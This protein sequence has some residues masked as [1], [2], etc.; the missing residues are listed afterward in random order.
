MKTRRHID[1]TLLH[2]NHANVQIKDTLRG[3]TKQKD[4]AFSKNYTMATNVYISC[5]LIVAIT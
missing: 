4:H 3:R 1:D 2:E 5:T